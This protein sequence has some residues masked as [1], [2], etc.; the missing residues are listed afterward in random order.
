MSGRLERVRSTARAVVYEVRSEDVTFMAASIAYHAFVSLL[1]ILGLLTLVVSAVGSERLVDRI[2]AT[3]ET[4]LPAAGQTVVSNAL[5]AS[6]GVGASVV[7]ITVLL[8]GTFK[9]FRAMDAAFSEIYDTERR[10]SVLDQARDGVVVF[11]SFAVAVLAVLFLGTWIDVPGSGSIQWLLDRLL[12]VAG[13]AV[14]LVPMYYVFPDLDVGLREVV[15]GVVVAAAGWTTLEW[16]FR[17]YVALSSKPDVYGIVGALL[18]LVTWLYVGSVLLLVGAAV[19]STL[20]GRAGDR[21]R[22]P[23]GK[24]FGRQVTDADSFDDRVGLLVARAREAGVPDGAIRRSLRRRAGATDGHED[25]TPERGD[26]AEPGRAEQA[27]AGRGRRAD[28]GRDH[29]ADASR[30]DGDGQA[31]DD[32]AADRC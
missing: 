29:R 27:D 17:W 1:P 13:L 9:I 6:G 14:A 26:A 23:T 11:L 5:T 18:L 10:N 7:G 15:P 19:N 22:K 25:T 3:T 2:L 21:T 24:R 20:A 31:S 32:S 30:V 28:C 12:A 16:A 8:W 4:V